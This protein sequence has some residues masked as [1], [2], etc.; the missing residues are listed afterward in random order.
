MSEM[1]DVGG[2]H[3]ELRNLF[4]V[5]DVHHGEVRQS[6]LKELTDKSADV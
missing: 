2:E 5:S 6:L 4:S 3:E 1:S